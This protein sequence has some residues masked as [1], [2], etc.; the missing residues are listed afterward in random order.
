M[1]KYTDRTELLLGKEAVAKLNESHVAIFGIGGVGGAATEALARAGVGKLTLVDADT[2][3]IT[4]INRQIFA[5]EEYIGK[6]KVEAAEKRLF[7]INSDIKLDLYNIFYLPDKNEKFDFKRFDYI[8]DAVDTVSAKIS[9]AVEACRVNTP[10]ISAMGAGNKLD[11]T[12][13]IVADIYKT[14]I[15]PLARIMRKELKERNI[16]S[17]KV[18]YSQEMPVARLNPPGSVSFV[19]PVVGMIMAGEVIKDIIKK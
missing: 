7:S 18:V 1:K 5:T 13:F 11:P 4:N 3:D 6:S 9:L 14:K 10:I 19:P 15:C 16:K 8:I 17:L 2:V 12:G